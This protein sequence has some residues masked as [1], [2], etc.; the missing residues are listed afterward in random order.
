MSTGRVSSVVRQER[1]EPSIVQVILEDRVHKN[2]F[3]AELCA[4]LLHAFASIASD[5]HCKV[6]IITGYDTYFCSG[7]T[8]EALLGLSDGQGKFTD[9]P[10]Y[11]LPLA[12]EVPVISAMQGHGI[13]GGLVFGLFADFVILS[14]ESVYT[15]NFMKYGFTP[16]FGSTLVLREKLGLPLAEELLMTADSYRGA[17]LA[18][19]GIPFPVLPR[20]EVLPYAHQLAK[21]LA[22]KPRQSLVTLKAHMV[23]GLRADLPRATDQEVAMHDQTFHQPEV[24]DRIKALFGK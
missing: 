10:I 4:G 18:E 12:C 1:I 6:V 3:S 14:R 13:G 9:Y 16:G 15:T 22:D 21:K 11:N 5:E 7:G 19:R 24:R 17:Q 20:S 2:T 23:A 8:Q